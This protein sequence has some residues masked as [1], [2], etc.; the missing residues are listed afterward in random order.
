[1]RDI[2]IPIKAR[3]EEILAPKINI[4]CTNYKKTS[5][6]IK[7]AKKYRLKAEKLQEAGELR[8]ARKLAIIVQLHLRHASETLAEELY[9]SMQINQTVI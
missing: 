3:L 2:S 6:H 9:S 8:K 5:A 1:M 4:S 7:A